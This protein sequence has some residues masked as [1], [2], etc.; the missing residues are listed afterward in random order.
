M[1]E[2]G[3][4]LAT[5]LRDYRMTVAATRLAATAQSS[6][7]T[8]RTGGWPAAFARAWGV[9]VRAPRT[10]TPVLGRV[11]QLREHLRSDRQLGDPRP[12]ACDRGRQRRTRAHNS[13]R[14]RLKR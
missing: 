3:T 2:A 9:I 8:F 7:G 10:T 14:E 13:V 11:E 5:I 1:R 6:N 4:P 12:E